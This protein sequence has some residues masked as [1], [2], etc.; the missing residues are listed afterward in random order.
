MTE[1][2]DPIQD[3]VAARLAKLRT[4]PVDVAHLDQR[5]AAELPAPITRKPRRWIAQISAAAASLLVIFT[6]M[7]VTLQGRPVQASPNLMA[8][9]HYDIV[10]GKVPTM[11]ADS[12]DEANEAIAAMAGN[13]LRLP[14]A[15]SAHT[16]ACCMR[17]LGNK[18]VACVLLDNGGPPVT[19]SVANARDISPPAGNT[20]SKNGITYHLQD[21]GKLH[22]ISFQKSNLWICLMS[23]APRD[24]LITLAEQ[25]KQ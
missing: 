20:T 24:T 21:T 17:N 18:K 7:F 14:N 1:E 4:F 2:N 10:A 16:M 25:L 15:P 8:Q 23:E 6:L 19:M 22:M 3:A 13:S 9:M 11:K 12:I 5:L